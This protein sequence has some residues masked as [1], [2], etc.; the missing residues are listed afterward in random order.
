MIR[1]SSHWLSPVILSLSLD[2]YGQE[3]AKAVYI[4]ENSNWLAAFSETDLIFCLDPVH[5]LFLTH[6]KI[7]E[8]LACGEPVF[9]AGQ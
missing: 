9:G 6:W 5:Y 3:T 8:V 7:V 1:L 4:V 2:R